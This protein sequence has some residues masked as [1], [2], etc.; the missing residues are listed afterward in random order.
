MKQTKERYEQFRSSRLFVQVIASVALVAVAGLVSILPPA[1]VARVRAALEWSVQ[2][3]YDFAGR[4]S[5]ARRWADDRGGWRPALAGAWQAQVEKARKLLPALPPADPEPQADPKPQATP[6]P[7]ANS[8]PPAP[9]VN[10]TTGGEKANDPAAE[11][12]MPVTGK[13]LYGFGW[14]PKGQEPHGGVDFA[15]AV[16][17]PV[18]AIADGTVLRVGTD[19]ALGGLVEVDHGFAVAL[20]GQVGGSKVRAGDKVT[21][22]QTLATVAR[23]TGKEGD[24]AAHLHLEMR[25]VRGGKTVDPAPFLPLD[26]GQGGDGT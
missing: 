8:T 25:A 24:R 19:P 12:V 9:A 17:A 11:T 5:A 7:Q 6:K 23:P 4:W 16:G 14:L 10:E 13:L 15:A 21:R 20:Y 22:G 26:A 18:S 1:R 2:H 3:D